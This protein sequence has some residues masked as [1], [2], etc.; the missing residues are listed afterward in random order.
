MKCKIPGCMRAPRPRTAPTG[1]APRT[2][3]EHEPHKARRRARAKAT[4]AAPPPAPARQPCPRPA[5]AAAPAAPAPAR[6]P[7]AG[8]SYGTNGRGD[9]EATCT[10]AYKAAA[11]SVRELDGARATVRAVVESTKSLPAARRVLVAAGL[12]ALGREVQR[13]IAVLS[14]GASPW[15][16]PACGP[17]TEEPLHGK[18]E[19]MHCPH[20]GCDEVVHVVGVEPV[21][22]EPGAFK[23]QPIGA[24]YR[25]KAGTAVYPTGEV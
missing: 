23:G 14:H 10:V 7:C 21:P 6:R 5:L 4:P 18:D 9:H 2:C 13:A 8:C 1:P 24:A 19:A 20:D 15:T 11:P 16:C 22:G 17:L 12:R 3:D 25:G